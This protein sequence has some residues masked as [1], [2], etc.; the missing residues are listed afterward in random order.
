M[1]R[2]EKTLYSLGWKRMD[3]KFDETFSLKWVESKSQINYNAFREGRYILPG[4]WR[5]VLLKVAYYAN[6]SARNF[7][8][9]CS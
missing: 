4:P 5:I 1:F 7:A 9:L 3:D 6:S 2:I 8:K